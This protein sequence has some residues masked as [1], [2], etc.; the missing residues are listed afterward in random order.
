[1]PCLLASA[2]DQVPDL[3]LGVDEAGRG[4]LA[5]PVCAAAVLAP[6]GYDFSRFSG[7]TDSKKLS[8]A[9]RAALADALLRSGLF[10]GLGQSWPE[11][12]DRVNILN[13]S[14]RAMSRAVLAVAGQTASRCGAPP[15]ADGFTLLVDGP[16]PIPEEQWR[17]AE[18]RPA[19]P[20][21]P[22]QRAIIR[23]DALVPLISAASILAKTRRDAL[24]LVLHQRHPLYGL[25]RHKG[26][27]TPLHLK[28]L[29]EHGPCPLHR[30]SF[31]PK[32]FQ[33]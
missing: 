23:G 2:K 30:R 19:W 20:A 33:P 21:P 15:D 13:A 3:Y 9:K 10:W 16:W 24:M 18:E 4:C 8:P 7:L 11:E 32:V 14:F 27:A 6:S 26:Y 25:D 22:R 1:M 5:G 29:A 28:K 17:A 31:Q 12:I